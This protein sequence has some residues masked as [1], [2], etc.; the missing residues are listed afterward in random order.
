[1][2]DT[3]ESLHWLYDA[4]DHDEVSLGF[5]AAVQ[6]TLAALRSP[7]PVLDLGCGTGLVA[8]RIA[9]TG[10]RV[11]GVDGS[12]PMLRRAR[13]RCRGRGRRVRFVQASLDDFQLE[14]PAALAIASGDVVNHFLSKRALVR[15]LRCVRRNLEPGSELVF[16]ALNR[17]CFEHY[18]DGTT[19]FSEGEAGDLVMECTWSPRSGIGTTRMIGYPKCG[20]GRHRKFETV[21]RERHWPDATL[22]AVLREAG[23]VDV[24]ATPWSPWPDQHLEPALDRNLWRARAPGGASR[25]GA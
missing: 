15:L 14:E 2:Q 21:L 24:R 6:P 19:W 8:D 3:Y 16:D 11:V 10:R 18:W 5:L 1:M 23:F 22:R 13:R 7:A 4:P 17:F 20:G 25:R 9:R 12:A